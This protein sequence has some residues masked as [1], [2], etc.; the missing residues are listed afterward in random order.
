VGRFRR[1]DLCRGGGARAPLDAGRRHF[2]GG[3][4]PPERH[5]LT[6]LLGRRQAVDPTEAGAETAEVGNIALGSKAQAVEML[7]IAPPFC[8]SMMGATRRVAR[9]TFMR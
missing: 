1:G 8:A 3:S 6:P 9:M 4:I 5:A 7:M 2:L